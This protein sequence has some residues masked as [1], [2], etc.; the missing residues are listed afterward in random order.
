M[1]DVHVAVAKFLGTVSCDC[2][3][4]LIRSKPGQ[5][6]EVTFALTKGIEEKNKIYQT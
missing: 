1:V 4:C 2:G 6:R 5:E 3:E